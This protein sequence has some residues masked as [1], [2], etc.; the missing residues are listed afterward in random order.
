MENNDKIDERL[1]KIEC[2]LERILRILEDDLKK[3]TEKMSNHIDFIETVYENIK[4][5]LGYICNKVNYFSK[6]EDHLSLEEDKNN[7]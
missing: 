6:S 1:K 7:N 5:P 4:N 2:K 3:N